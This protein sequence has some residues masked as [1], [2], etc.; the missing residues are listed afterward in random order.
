VS[1]L[2]DELDEALRAI[3]TRD[4]PVEAAMRGGRRIRL[5]RRLGAVVTVAAVAV[6]AIVGYPALTRHSAGPAPAP[7][8]QHK[9]LVV[10]AMPP[11]MGS[12]DNGLIAL[13]TIGATRWRVSIDFS[14]PADQCIVGL[15]GSDSVNGGCYQSG[16]LNGPADGS[17]VSLQ[18]DSDR[19]YTVTVGGVAANVTYLIVTLAD[20]QQLKLIPVTSHGHRYVGYALPAGLRVARV[21]AYLGNGQELTAIPFNQPGFAGTVLERWA[22][23]GQPEPPSATALIGSGTLNGHPW[24]VTAYVG[25]WGTCLLWTEG[26]AYCWAST[27]TP[28]AG[29]IGSVTDSAQ[30][31]FGAVTASV[32]EVKVTLTDG[33]SSLLPVKAAGGER[34]WAFALGKG[35][36]L[37]NWTGYDAAGRQ[38]AT[39]TL[40]GK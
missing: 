36:H 2:H 5:R 20:G 17:P 22:P 32:A 10:T 6:F 24:S 31:V 8:V 13:G 38:V 1:D 3:T 34:L 40:P 11:G 21:T 14:S 29:I 28:G 27:R 23:P 7:P 19:S 37:K 33:T 26:G 39:G 30:Y 18:G 9:R 25:P 4:A 15:V 35:Q 16:M 12:P